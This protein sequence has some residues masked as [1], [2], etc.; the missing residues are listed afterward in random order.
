[1]WMIQG[2]AKNDHKNE[3]FYNIFD[4]ITKPTLKKAVFVPLWPQP[5]I[6]FFDGEIFRGLENVFSLLGIAR[7]FASH[8]GQDLALI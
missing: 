1:M 2:Y 5:R 3:F 7:H 6:V 4:H 8:N